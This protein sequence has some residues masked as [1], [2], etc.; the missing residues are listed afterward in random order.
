MKFIFACQVL[1]ELRK[2]YLPLVGVVSDPAFHNVEE[3]L[4]PE[5]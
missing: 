5:Y 4:L 2:A 1:N 3:M